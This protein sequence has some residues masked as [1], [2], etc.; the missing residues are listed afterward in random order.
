M[1]VYY[2]WLNEIGPR[3]VGSLETETGDAGVLLQLDV[4]IAKRVAWRVV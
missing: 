2:V 4:D 3:A 1:H